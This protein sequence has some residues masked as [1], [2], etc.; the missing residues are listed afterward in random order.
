MLKKNK[1]K[2]YVI[3]GISILAILLVA[4]I[5]VVGVRAY[6]TYKAIQMDNVNIETININ[7]SGGGDIE[8]GGTTAADWNVGGALNVTGATTFTGALTVG[9]EATLEGLTSGNGA[10]ASST[11]AGVAA[12]GTLTQSDLLAY[13]YLDFTING[14]STF[15]LTLPATS[16]MTTLLD[17]VGETRNWVIHNATSTAMVMTITAGTGIDLIGVTTNDDV[18]DETEYSELECWRQPDTDVTCRI[19]ELLHVD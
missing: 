13:N 8:L 11:T 10:L 12:A 18:I 15:A 3:G 17:T 14:G 1:E 7:G 6:E 4:I 16:T 19:S 5:G 2:L 9:G